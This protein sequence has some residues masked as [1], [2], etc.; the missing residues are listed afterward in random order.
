MDAHLVRDEDD[1]YSFLHD[2]TT[3]II[4]FLVIGEFGSWLLLYMF[5]YWMKAGVDM[6]GFQPKPPSLYI[7]TPY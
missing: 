5:G 4:F 1:N 3:F 2:P 7:L 6:L